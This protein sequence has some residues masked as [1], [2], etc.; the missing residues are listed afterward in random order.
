MAVGRCSSSSES[1]FSSS[2]CN[3]ARYKRA[4]AGTYGQLWVLRHPG[5]AEKAQPRMVSGMRI[6]RPH[7]HAA[8]SHEAAVHLPECPREVAIAAC[9]L[10]PLLPPSSLRQ[11]RSPVVYASNAPSH[12]SRRLDVAA[13]LPF[14]PWPLLSYP[15][16]T[17]PKSPLSIEN[18]LLARLEMRRR[19]LRA[20]TVRTRR[21]STAPAT[22]YPPNFHSPCSPRPFPAI[23]QIPSN[24]PCNHH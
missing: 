16:R 14:P 8:L 2:I 3:P 13:Q 6:M 18:E 21:G 19:V 7:L 22:V 1:K 15:P 24:S 10:P 20:R 17:G 12:A 4:R 23:A 11:V 5:A 9:T